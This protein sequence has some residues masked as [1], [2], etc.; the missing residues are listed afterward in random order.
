[1]V[2]PSAPSS[3]CLLLPV[4]DTIENDEDVDEEKTNEQQQLLTA[5]ANPSTNNVNVSESFSEPPR[6]TLKLSVDVKQ[7][8]TK[9][10]MKKMNMNHN[11]NPFHQHD[12]GSNVITRE[13]DKE[14][15]SSSYPLKEESQTQLS[16]PLLEPNQPIMME[17]PFDTWDN[18][19]SL[20]NTPTMFPAI[21]DF[22]I[23][24]FSMD[25]TEAAK[26]WESSKVDHDGDHHQNTTTTANITTT[27]INT[28][29]IAASSASFPVTIKESMVVKQNP[30]SL[31][32]VIYH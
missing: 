31:K 27:T 13:L 22:A 12:L 2:H 16:A 1:M 21:D 6:K 15:I 4:N 18:N 3:S 17:D 24:D 30:R 10:K 25:E 11:I 19:M 9:K 8:T 32:R 14:E 23:N 28:A 29:A 26:L 20:T 5:L 7:H